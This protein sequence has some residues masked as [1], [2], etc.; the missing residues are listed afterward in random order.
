MTKKCS[1]C[2]L[3][4][5]YNEFY[6]HPLTK[7]GYSNVCKTCQ[8]EYSSKYAEKNREKLKEYQKERYLRRKQEF[9]ELKRL[10]EKN[11]LNQGNN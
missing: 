8:K 1:I 4:K 3:E 2:G 7:D 6:S 5:E 10:V 11:G 9:A